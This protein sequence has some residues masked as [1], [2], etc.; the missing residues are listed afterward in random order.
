MI[1]PNGREL[2]SLMHFLKEGSSAKIAPAFPW[3]AWINIRPRKRVDHDRV[4][5][6]FT[7][8]TTSDAQGCRSD[9]ANIS[10]F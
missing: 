8:I 2:K 5:M 10:F 3:L 1:A 9:R 6:V 4:S 7:P